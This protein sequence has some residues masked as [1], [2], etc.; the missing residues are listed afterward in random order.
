MRTRRLFRTDFLLIA[1]LST[2]LI[3]CAASAAAPTPPTLAYDRAPQIVASTDR[4]AADRTNDIRRH[5]AEL[6]TFIGVRPGWTALDVSTGGGYT[7]ELLAR[8][9]GP[10]GTVYEQNQPRDPN[11]APVTPAAPEGGAS[12]AATP[13]APAAVSSASPRAQRNTD[14]VLAD[15]ERSLQV[16]GVAEQS[17]LRSEVEAAGFNLTSEGDFLR[18]PNDPRDRNTLSRRSR[19]TSSC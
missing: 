16:A 12:P 2:G 4:S 1:L 10:S 8:A 7:A 11:M 18:N 15:R 13:A 17:F 6:L 5:P 14:D 19:R 9:I 3:G